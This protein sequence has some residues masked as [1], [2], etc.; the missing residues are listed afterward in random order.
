MLVHSDERTHMTQFCLFKNV[1][2]GV[3]N[4]RGQLVCLC[5][6]LECWKERVCSDVGD[7]IFV[8]SDVALAACLQNNIINFFPEVTL[9]FF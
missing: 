5:I 9:L 6:L 8:F 7:K 3:W 4:Y 2:Q 1:Q